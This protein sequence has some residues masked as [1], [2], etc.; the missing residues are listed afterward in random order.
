MFDITLKK[1]LKCMGRAC[2]KWGSLGKVLV[3]ENGYQIV[4]KR[5]WVE[6][7][8]KLFM[9]YFAKVTASKYIYDRLCLDVN[10]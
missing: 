4:A 3:P 2:H 1:T 6:S 7:H 8:S 10:S 9:T 5:K